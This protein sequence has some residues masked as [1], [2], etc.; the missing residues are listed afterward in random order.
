MFMLNMTCA[1]HHGIIRL[2]HLGYK[3]LLHRSTETVK[4][5]KSPRSLTLSEVDINLCT[6]SNVV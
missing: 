3:P 5:D 1:K 6:D 2:N 4:L